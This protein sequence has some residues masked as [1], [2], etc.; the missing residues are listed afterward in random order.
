MGPYS[1][2]AGGDQLRINAFGHDDVDVAFDPLLTNC[3]FPDTADLAVLGTLVF[4]CP[5]RDSIDVMIPDC[6][7]GT[8]RSFPVVC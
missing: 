8:R 4:G 5:T 6:L 3:R 7:L 1:E 2:D